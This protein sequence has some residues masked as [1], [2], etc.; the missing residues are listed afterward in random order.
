MLLSATVRAGLDCLR[1]QVWQACTKWRPQKLLGHC[2]PKRSARAPTASRT[3]CS[4]GEGGHE[5]TPD[6]SSYEELCPQD[7]GSQECRGGDAEARR[8]FLIGRAVRERR[9]G[10]GLS[11]VEP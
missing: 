11:Q 10:L 3:R 5:M 6:P 1:R 4:S 8:A 2:K 7:G 9:M